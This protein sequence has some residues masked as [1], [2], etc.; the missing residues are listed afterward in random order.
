MTDEFEDFFS[1]L[2]KPPRPEPKAKPQA[3]PSSVAKPPRRK[4]RLKGEPKLDPT[5]QVPAPRGKVKQEKEKPASK[6][7]TASIPDRRDQQKAL[8]DFFTSCLKTK[9]TIYIGI[10]T[11][12]QGAIG[13]LHPSD[14]RQTTVIDMPMVEIT[15]GT[16]TKSKKNFRKRNRLDLATLWNY[17]KV[18]KEW[19]HR[20]VV[21]LETAQPR[22]TDNGI[23]GFAVGSNYA[24]WPLFLYSH[25]I[26]MA[27][28]NPLVWK[29]A[30][31]LLGK[32]K[33]CSRLMAQKLWPLASLSRVG[34]HNRA[35]ALLLAE[36]QRR[37]SNGL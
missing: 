12:S 33:E 23:T 14:G 32:D 31:G 15:L 5:Q 1:E 24:T 3:F 16:K 11:G 34:D 6:P 26:P 36:Y 27:E 13:L 28:A 4:T 17:F 21:C 29:R 30:M 8:E 18:V 25:E 22:A 20:V 35:E 37:K 10:D 7:F 9:G 2:T 19:R